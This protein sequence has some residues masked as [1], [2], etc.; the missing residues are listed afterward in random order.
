MSAELIIKLKDGES[1]DDAVMSY[2]RE[3]LGT[4][5]AMAALYPTFG[6]IAEL[7][8]TEYGSFEWI[9]FYTDGRYET[10]SK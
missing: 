5:K 7:V 6:E 8:R 4:K 3:R 1:A 9:K 2:V 10:V